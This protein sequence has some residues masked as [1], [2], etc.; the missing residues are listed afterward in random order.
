MR[1]GL[2]WEGCMARGGTHLG[3]MARGRPHLIG[4]DGEGWASFGKDA[5][6]GVGLIWEGW[7]G[8]PHLIGKD[9]E[10]WASFNWEGW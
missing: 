3:R 2:I 10:G 9:G 1:V 5:W 8:R 6:Q 4:K 7:R